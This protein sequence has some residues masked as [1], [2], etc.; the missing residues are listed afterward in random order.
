M[1]HTNHRSGSAESL[2]D[3]FVVLAVSAP[4]INR[5]GCAE[6][7]RQLLDIF[8][9]H[10]PNNLGVLGYESPVTPE[11]AE[12]VKA[13]MTDKNGPVGC[14]TSE[15][16]ISALLR[17]VKEADL[18]ISIV[19]SGLFG[20]VHEC[21]RKNGIEPHTVN[22]SL[23]VWGDVEHKL[24][25]D[26]RVLDLTTMCGHGMIPFTL[27]ESVLDRVK[28]GSMTPQQAADKLSPTC[29]CRIFNTKRAARII[30][31]IAGVKNDGGAQ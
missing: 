1:S 29:T 19:V 16:D 2:R 7:I 17:E 20:E 11:N 10:N 26:S 31:D 6:K 23:G 12:D 27:V 24:P 4:G 28:A 18:G 25:A 3:D 9:R 22:M 5:E 14:F 8:L 13:Y 30:A 21:C 15:E